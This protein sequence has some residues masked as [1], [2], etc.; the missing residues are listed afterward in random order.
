M[1]AHELFTLVFASGLI[2]LM[3]LFR[4]ELQKVAEDLNN[5]RGGPPSPMGPLPST[6]AH[7]LLKRRRKEK[8]P[9]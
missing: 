5:R 7:L 6:D 9:L 8:L 2:G 1:T 4:R 3:I